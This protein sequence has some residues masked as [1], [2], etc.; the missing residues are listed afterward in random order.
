MTLEG[1][2]KPEGYLDQTHTTRIHCEDAWQIERSRAA[3]DETI[4][5]KLCAVEARG[6]N[7]P[8]VSKELASGGGRPRPQ[9]CPDAKGPQGKTSQPEK[10]T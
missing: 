7:A 4:S 3:V 8:Q 6:E 5:Y 1:R 2:R 9:A 10:K